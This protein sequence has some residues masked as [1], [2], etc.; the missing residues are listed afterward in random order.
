MK[1][2]QKQRHQE[3]NNRSSKNNEKETEKEEK[4][5]VLI[6]QENATSQK[7]ERDWF[8]RRE[9]ARNTK[10]FALSS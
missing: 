8:A 9:K 7:K 1:Y 10:H 6:A 2:N 3:K 4:T 5:E